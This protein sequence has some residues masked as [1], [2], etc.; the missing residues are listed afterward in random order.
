MIQYYIVKAGLVDHQFI[1]DRCEG[2]EEFLEQIKK[3]DVDAM[4]EI[5]GLDKD[6]VKA[7]AL[8]YANAKNA[9]EFH[10]LGVTEHTHRVLKQLCLFQI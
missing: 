8:A 2:G 4:A 9:M 3:L 5:S 1:K 10:G 7:V 6:D